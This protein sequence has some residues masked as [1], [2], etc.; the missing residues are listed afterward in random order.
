[1]PF[2]SFSPSARTTKLTTVRSIDP[3]GE[4]N[5]PA[6]GLL[7]VAT[8]ACVLALTQ[9]HS[10]I[11]LL[12]A[13]WPT[14]EIELVPAS[15]P[16]DRDKRTP[17][18]SL[19][20]GV[21]VKGIE[22]ELLSDRADIAVHSVKDVPTLGTPT[23]ELAAFPKRADPR[24]GL[25]CRIGRCLAELPPGARVGTGSPRR[26][27]QL[28]AVRSDVRV[29]PIRGNLDTRLRRLHDGE[30]EA[31]VVA[32]AGLA[33]LGRLS[34]LHH[35]FSFEECTPAAGQGAL[36]V[37]ARANDSA[38]R[39][40][41]TAIDDPDCRAEVQ[42]ERAFLASLGGGCQ[43]P[44]GAVARASGAAL[45]LIGVAASP[46]GRE[47]T[48]EQHCGRTSAPSDLGRGL[49]ERMLPRARG[50]LALAGA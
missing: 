19:G 36:V 26:A 38:T 49:A 14:L 35:A 23:L 2:A 48:R 32:V 40:L 11:A 13:A 37:Q 12:H 9:T 4:A 44:A 5:L 31:L 7:R 17:L 47:L 42:A 39:A 18:T 24:D 43:L 16:G 50:L 27:A 6:R 30:F 34:E 1:M 3:R 33:R 10:V 20:E 22:E 21:F 41:V 15:T 45:K 46:D 28:L 25:V 8:R 29:A